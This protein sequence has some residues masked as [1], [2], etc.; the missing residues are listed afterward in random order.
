MILVFAN[1][2]PIHITCGPPPNSTKVKG[3]DPCSNLD[4][5]NSVGLRK[6]YGNMWG[7]HIDQNIGHIEE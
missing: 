3:G 1:L 7:R 5:S 2:L 6:I 4:G